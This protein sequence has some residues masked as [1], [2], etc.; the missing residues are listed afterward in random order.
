MLVKVKLITCAR[1]VRGSFKQIYW[2]MYE[3]LFSVLEL[4]CTS[5]LLQ[6]LVIR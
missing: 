5:M 6:Q 1:N 2:R 4:P 3:Y